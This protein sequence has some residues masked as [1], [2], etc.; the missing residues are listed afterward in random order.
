MERYRQ[1]GRPTFLC[2]DCQEHIPEK[3]RRCG[4]CGWQGIYRSAVRSTLRRGLLRLINLNFGR[5]G[6][7][8]PCPSCQWAMPKNAK[9]C[10]L[11]LRS[12]EVDIPEP[13]A[14]SRVL[15]HVRREW[16]RRAVRDAVNCPVCTVQVPPWADGCLC[17]GWQRPRKT[18]QIAM[19]GYALAEVK[20][21]VLERFQRNEEI[22]P[23]GDWCPECDI[24][25]P[26]SDKKCMI[27][28]WE[29][30]REKS[31]LEAA[32]YLVHE[33]KL[34]GAANDT[35]LRECSVCHVPMT[36]R[37]K[38]CLVCGWTPPIK[39]PVVRL[40]RT[41]RVR[42]FRK[43]G[44]SWQPCP[45][46]RLPLTRHAVKC[47]TC[48]WEKAPKRYW[49]KPPRISWLVVTV[50]LAVLYFTV[51]FFIVQMADTTGLH[52]IRDNFGRDLKGSSFQSAPIPTP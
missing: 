44:P 9:R 31:I 41:K 12:P 51:Q 27:C 39:N 8:I 18:G 4:Y 38:M 6:E 22:A 14:F 1:S 25:V 3:A 7:T 11:C 35:S 50:A 19:M 30:D 2:P 5:S 17:C 10:P 24:L 16:I 43:Y 29:P 20:G 49:G 40:L 52:S 28:G 15:L 26:P 23:A 13:T 34:R 32:Q 46:C 45:S 47:F 37:A 36:P 21:E 33:I 48:G 42:K